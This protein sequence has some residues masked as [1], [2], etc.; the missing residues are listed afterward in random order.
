M[1]EG[2]DF[3][4]VEGEDDGWQLMQVLVS[5]RSYFVPSHSKS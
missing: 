4:G 3:D 5:S 1:F 2:V